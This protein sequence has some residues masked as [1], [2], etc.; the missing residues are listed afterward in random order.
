[1]HQFEINRLLELELFGL[2]VSF[3]NSSLFMVLAVGIALA[4]LTM[5]MGNRSLVPSKMQSVAELTYEFVANMVSENV[6]KAGMKYF[7]F[8]FSLFIFVLMANML[9]M[10]PWS[11][12]V[13]SH[14]VVTFALAAL[15]F[16]V[17]TAIGF[18]RHGLGYLKLFVPEG[19]PFWLMPLI[20]PIELISYLI[21]P[22]SLSV[23]LFANMMAGHTMLKVFAG[24]VVS[25]GAIG[26][27]APLLATVAFTGL[28]FVVAF[29]QAFIFTVLTCIYLNDA[30]NMHHH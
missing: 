17:V 11:F 30:V 15:V 10:L 1:M 12:T 16:V 7:P 24:F 22:I 14:I 29:L 8:V 18:A 5:A 2:D 3:T 6:G 25:L 28:E 9:G 27:I 26:G 4:F 21:R 20:V 13:T 19:V 23:R